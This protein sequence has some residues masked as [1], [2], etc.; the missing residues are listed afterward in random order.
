MAGRP[1]IFQGVAL[2]ATV[3]SLTLLAL[4]VERRDRRVRFRLAGDAETGLETYLP[5]ELLAGTARYEREAFRSN[6]D[7]D[8]RNVAVDRETNRGGRLGDFVA[9]DRLGD[10]TLAQHDEGAK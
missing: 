8:L 4:Q 10:V 9:A 7:A 2:L 5:R 1:D 3:G 6:P